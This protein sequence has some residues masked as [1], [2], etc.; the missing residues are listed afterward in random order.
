MPFFNGIEILL[1]SYE[2]Y[3]INDYN[4][5]FCQIHSSGVLP[6]LFA[7]LGKASAPLFQIFESQVIGIRKL[8]VTE[9]G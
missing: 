7:T 4:L 3:E 2:Y 5:T 6:V 8:A 1:H 9:Q